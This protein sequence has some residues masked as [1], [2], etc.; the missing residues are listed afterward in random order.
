LAGHQ[1]LKPASGSINRRISPGQPEQ[2]MR[3]PQ[4]NRAKGVVIEHPPSQAQGPEFKVQYHQKII[5]LKTLIYL[6]GI[7]LFDAVCH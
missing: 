6:E 7:C 1:W 3:L 2:K 5:I 4:N